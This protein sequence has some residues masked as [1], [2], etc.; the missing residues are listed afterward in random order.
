MRICGLQRVSTID[1][2]GEVCCVVFLKGCNFRCGFCYN[3]ALVIGDG[4]GN[5]SESSKDD[6]TEPEYVLD[7]L[8]RRVGKLDGVCISGGEPLMSLDFDFVR[9]VRE[10]GFKVKV[11]TNGSFPG[12]LKEMIDLGLVDYIA[13]DVKGCRGDYSR[14]VNAE[15]DLDAV[16]KSMKMVY[17]FGGGENK[18]R[19]STDEHGFRGG[20]KGEGG[21]G[22]RTN[23][24]ER[25]LGRSEFRT[26]VVGRYHNV[27]NLIEMGKWMNEVCGGKPGRFFLQGFKSTGD[28]VDSSFDE[29]VSVSE[30]ILLELKA[31]IEEY[32]GEV[33]IRV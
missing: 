25:G 26:T 15:V 5:F 24:D 11:D 27:G 9:R 20:E 33:G 3:P 29:E 16:E 19:T 7:F 14:I 8:R 4:D 10:M 6:P 13:M 2:P 22:T 1:Y 18:P 28:F 32:F 31:S 30:K 23:V 12:R 21:I 17:D